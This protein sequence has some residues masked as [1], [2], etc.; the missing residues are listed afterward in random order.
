MELVLKTSEGLNSPWVRIP[1]SPPNMETE[2]EGDDPLACEAGESES[3]SRRSPQV[4]GAG[5]RAAR[6]VLVH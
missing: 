2:G 6:V 5:V 1:S 4:F 3:M